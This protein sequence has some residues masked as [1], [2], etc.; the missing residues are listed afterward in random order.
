MAL[1]CRHRYLLFDY[2]GNSSSARVIGRV[3]AW[4]DGMWICSVITGTCKQ[5]FRPSGWTVAR[6]Q[7]S[8][9]RILI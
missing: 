6:E 8:L 4:V 3:A 7:H 1:A 9:D 2:V 5:V